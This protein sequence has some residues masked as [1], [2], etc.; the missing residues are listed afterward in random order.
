MLNRIIFVI[1]LL[2][3]RLAV[4]PKR[5]DHVVVASCDEPTLCLAPL[6]KGMHIV[7]HNSATVHNKVKRWCMKRLARH[8]SFLVFDDYMAEPLHRAGLH[9]V[10]V[11]SHGCV[12]A[13]GVEPAVPAWVTERGGYKRLV[14]H[15]S[16]KVDEAFL[17]QMMADAA[18]QKCL[19]RDGVLMVFQGHA[20]EGVQCPRC[21]RFVDRYLSMHEY[22]SM[23]LAADVILLAYPSSFQR[24]VSGVSYECVA[25]GKPMVALKHP[26]LGYCAAFFN[27]D[28]FVATAEE[29]ADRLQ[30]IFS[31]PSLG[32]T[33]TPRQLAPHYISVFEK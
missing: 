26:A 20:P 7:L 3:I 24:Q 2:Y 13:F 17:R 18:L 15:P 4:H 1:T 32:C 25:N 30:S 19:D 28:P 33:A 16:A 5:Y 10:D 8:N 11:I 14:Y 31:D 27:Y 9:C 6:C 12:P 23:F 29:L 21:I 22:R